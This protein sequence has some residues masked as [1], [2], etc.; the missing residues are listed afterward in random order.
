MFVSGRCHFPF[1]TLNFPSVPTPPEII[2]TGI[3]DLQVLKPKSI[4]AVIG[5]TVLSV[6]DNNVSLSCGVTGFPTPTVQ[7]TKDGVLLQAEESILSL[8]S[9]DVDDTGLYTCTAT[10]PLGS[11]DSQSTNLTV[12]GTCFTH[13]SLQRDLRRPLKKRFTKLES[14]VNLKMCIFEIKSSIIEKT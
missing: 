6:S 14:S 3:K 10:S 1:N 9:V 7:W 4:E 8:S 12:I 5:S 11:F 13:F 2:R